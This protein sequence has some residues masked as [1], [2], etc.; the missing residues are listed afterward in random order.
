MEGKGLLPKQIL[1][2]LVC[3]RLRPL[4][5]FLFM[6]YSGCSGGIARYRASTAERSSQGAQTAMGRKRHWRAALDGQNAVIR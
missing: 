3:T 6:T 5:I 2:M 1:K 4:S